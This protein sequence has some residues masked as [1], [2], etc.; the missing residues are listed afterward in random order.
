MRIHHLAV[1]SPDPDRLARFYA[2]VLG[3]PE[4]RRQA[5]D[6]G[7]RSVWLDAGGVILMVERGE[8]AAGVTV[9][10][11]EPGSAAAWRARLGPAFDG[12]TEFTVYGRDPDGNRFGL[13]AYPAPIGPG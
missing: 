13:S 11:A 5:D 3:L 1:L 9:F 10:A 7:V 12:R 8:R 4:L 2:T 6:G